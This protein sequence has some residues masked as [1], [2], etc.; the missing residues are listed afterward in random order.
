RRGDFDRG[1]R[2]G[3]QIR[4]C[5]ELSPD[6]PETGLGK[7][8]FQGESHIANAIDPF[9]VIES[10]VAARSKEQWPQVTTMDPDKG[11]PGRQCLQ[12]KF[13][14]GEIRR[15]LGMPLT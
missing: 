5:N 6:G 13:P 8:A 14:I 2:T 4:K 12:R 9:R 15:R 1:E 3:T 7:S 11:R 10:V